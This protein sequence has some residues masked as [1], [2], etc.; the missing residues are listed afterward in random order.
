MARW[1]VLDLAER[2][3]GPAIHAVNR[4]EAYDQG[5]ARYGIRC[6]SVQSVLSYEVQR[7]ADQQEYK[8][9]QRRPRRWRDDT[10]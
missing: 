10:G 6:A 2:I 5:C 1:Y 3:L 9:R 8:R 7:A 4:T